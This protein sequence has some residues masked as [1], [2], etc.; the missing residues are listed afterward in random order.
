MDAMDSP[1][2]ENDCVTFV[3]D[4]VNHARKTLL[5][6][7]NRKGESG[8]INVMTEALPQTIRRT[9]HSKNQ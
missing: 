4:K 3:R 5:E 2:Y 7:K 9:F 1:E 6:K 8:T